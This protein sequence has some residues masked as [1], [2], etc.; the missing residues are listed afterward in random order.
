MVEKKEKEI[1]RVKTGNEAIQ[2]SYGKMS[3][4]YS[5]AEGFFEKGL[6][7][8]ALELLNIQEGEIVLE[9]GFGTGYSLVEIA[10]RIGKTNKVSGIDLTPQMVEMTSKR[11]ERAGLADRVELYEGDARGLPFENNIFDAVYIATTL[12]LFDA[13]DIPKVL[14][15]IKRVLKPNGRLG[16][17]SLSKEGH[18][19]SLFLKLYEWLHKKIPKYIDCRPIYVADCIREAGYKIMKAEELRVVRLAPF[20]VVIASPE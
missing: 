9:I 14:Q 12:E 4:Y 1:L 2:E 20:K 3:K 17:A 8:G 6:R 11:L 5:L 19:S 13:H 18:E 10:K 16:V 15:Q 7:K